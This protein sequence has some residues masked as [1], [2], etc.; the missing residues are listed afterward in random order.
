[1][2][3]LVVGAHFWGF[4]GLAVAI[5]AAATVNVVIQVLVGIYYRSDYYG[6]QVLPEE[7]EDG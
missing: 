4:L 7:R 3:A 6:P 2:F 5:P 1:M